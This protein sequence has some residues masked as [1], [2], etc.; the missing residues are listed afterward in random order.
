MKKELT[1]YD[2]QSNWLTWTKLANHTVS[3]AVDIVKTYQYGYQLGLARSLGPEYATAEQIRELQER[4]LKHLLLGIFGAL[5]LLL[6][7]V[8]ELNRD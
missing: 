1:R 2:S 6:S 4:R 3:S 8:G 7:A 5:L